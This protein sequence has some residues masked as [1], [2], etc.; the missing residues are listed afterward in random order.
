M[1]ADEIYQVF[2]GVR[3]ASR[4]TF[5]AAGN[6]CSFTSVKLVVEQPWIAEIDVNPLL[7]SPER[8]LALDAR[9]VL[10]GPASADADLPSSAIRPYRSVRLDMDAEGRLDGEIRPIPPRTSVAG[11][12]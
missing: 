10:H 6:G 1:E 5:A 7:A 3:G 2:K 9:M 8:L 4:S 12:V 11:E